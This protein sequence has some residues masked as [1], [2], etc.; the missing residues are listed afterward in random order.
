MKL[1]GLFRIVTVAMLLMLLLCGTAAAD[2]LVD[3]IGAIAPGQMPCIGNPKVL[4]FCVTFPGGKVSEG[5]H[6]ISLSTEE[7]ENWFFSPELKACQDSSKTY[8]ENDSIRSYFYRSSYGKVDITGDVYEY[9]AQ[10]DASY[11]TD[12]NLLFD[13]VFTYYEDQ[14]SWADY[15]TNGDGYLDGA[16][17]LARTLPAWTSTN[18][19]NYVADHEKMVGGI[20]INRVCYIRSQEFRTFCHETYH[21]FGLGDIY[22]GTGL[23]PAGIN[24]EC[25]MGGGPHGGGLGDIPGISKYILGWMDN[26]HFVSGLG[27][28]TIDLLSYSTAAD[29]LVVYPNGDPA[30]SNWFVVEYVTNQANNLYDGI[31]IWRTNMEK[32]DAEHNILGAENVTVGR[33]ESPMEYIEAISPED[34]YNYY[35]Q[36]G[37]AVSPTS[38]PSSAYGTEYTRIGDHKYITKSAYSGITIAVD[39]ISGDTASLTVTIE[40][41]PEGVKG[42]ASLTLIDPAQNSEYIDILDGFHFATILSDCEMSLGGE[43]YILDTE[44]DQTIPVSCILDSKG[45]NLR[46]VI[47]REYLAQISLDHTYRLLTTGVL[48]SYA[49]TEIEI[50]DFDGTFRF[51]NLVLAL[52]D[53]SESYYL[54]RTSYGWWANVPVF[55]RLDDEHVCFADLDT[56]TDE[57][58]LIL[59]NTRNNTSER[60][61][62]ESGIATDYTLP[63]MDVWQVNDDC[64]CVL[65]QMTDSSSYLACYSMDGKKLDG[66]MLN[67]DVYETVSD[68]AGAFII[69]KTNYDRDRTTIYEVSI[70]NDQLVLDELDFLYDWKWAGYP[71]ERQIEIIN[72]NDDGTYTIAFTES[73]SL[74]DDPD[75]RKMQIVSRNQP[76]VYLEAGKA[77][78]WLSVGDQSYHVKVTVNDELAVDVYSADGTVESTVT[79]MKKLPFFVAWTMEMETAYEDGLLAIWFNSDSSLYEQSYYTTCLLVFDQYFQLRGYYHGSTTYLDTFSPLYV[80]GMTF[81]ICGENSYRYVSPGQCENNTPG[82]QMEARGD[83]AGCIQMNTRGLPATCTS[84]GISAGRICAVCSQ[85]FVEPK[86]IPAAGKMHVW[87]AGVKVNDSSCSNP[88]FWLY[89][90]TACGAAHKTVSIA[91]DG[92]RCTMDYRVEP[93][94]CFDG[95][96][97]WRC[98]YCPY[99]YEEQIPARGGGVFET[100][101]TPAT[102]EGEGEI[103]TVC[104]NCW[105]T[106]ER[107]VI[108]PAGHQPVEVPGVAPTCCETGLTAGS[109]CD[110]CG[111]VF[112]EQTVI[113][114]TGLHYHMGDANE[115]GSIDVFDALLILQYNAG[116]DVPIC[117]ENADANGDGVVGVDDAL[118]ILKSCLGDLSRAARALQI[119]LKNMSITTLEIVTQPADQYA[120]EGHRAEFA[121]SAAG[122]GVAYQWYINRNDGMGWMQLKEAADAAYATSVLERSNDGYQYRC[123]LRDVYGS[124]LVSDTAV[125]YVTPEIPETGDRAQPVWWAVLCVLS[126]A[127]IAAMLKKRISA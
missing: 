82:F 38:S 69:N 54:D 80:G 65:I 7:V 13:E 72:K 91:A 45:M 114:A 63:Y 55:M 106:L 126:L 64:F 40:N 108:P 102:C 101:S 76:A 20:R 28:Q 100:R 14:I 103:L 116:W 113:P 36:A 81:L 24:T 119:M 124:E 67:D 109:V 97:V 121:V 18:V 92:H 59:L 57:L 79:L 39:S 58:S 22:A 16:Y 123:V 118:Q 3:T 43:M 94:C 35:Y 30:N 88:G 77:S 34:A 5:I 50:K 96:E 9:T 48:L 74:T 12:D 8:S 115:D 125:L 112:V 4:V 83:A 25:I 17:F 68:S 21:M 66:V 85:A 41:K 19:N 44:N 10:N 110:V 15:D 78:R 86:K 84:A 89:S 53:V 31:R 11:Y 95:Y 70:V 87:D 75:Y 62:L 127:G 61:L 71:I 23:N 52:T 60:H 98:S 32:L 49:G 120:A 27:S 90:C 33:P 1:R 47:A 29:L 2:R 105:Y 46:L 26:V 51:A 6:H 111:Y 73:N 56:Y 122:D 93:T 42:T 37:E 104:I 107:I 99:Q 117:I